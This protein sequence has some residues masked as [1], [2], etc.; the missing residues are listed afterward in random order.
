MI[1]VH[2]MVR[3]EPLVHLALRAALRR[4][5]VSQAVVIDTGST[6]DTYSRIQQVQREFP[7]KV[8]L[9]Q[10]SVPDA[11]KWSYDTIDNP[12]KFPC[13]EIHEVIN[14]MIVNDLIW[15]M[16]GDEIYRNQGVDE[17]VDICKD[18]PSDINAIYLPLLWF[19]SKYK[20]VTDCEPKVGKTV[21][22]LFKKQGMK[23][24]GIFPHEMAFYDGT[25]ADIGLPGVM[26]ANITPFHHYEP[27][28]KP[29]RRKILS[30]EDYTGPQ[31]EVFIGEEL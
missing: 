27:M 30:T 4:E 25:V 29:W 6:D 26:E 17:V 10:L 19:S 7:G 12:P 28:L 1:S 9:H 20:L 21:G 23:F 3:N 16:D 5:E 24:Q 31:P 8:I 11:T 14:S 18:W 15:L 2:T 13:S 22:R